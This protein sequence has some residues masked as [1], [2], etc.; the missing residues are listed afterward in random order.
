MIHAGDERVPPPSPPRLPGTVVYRPC[1]DDLIDAVLADLLLQSQSCVRAFGDFHLA[2]CA[3]ERIEPALVRLMLDPMYRSLPWKRTHLW[4]ADDCV[5]GADDDRSRAKRM[6]EIL[7][8]H[9]DIPVDQVHGI[10]VTSR[11]PGGQYQADLQESLAWRE[12]GQ[13]RLDFAL[14]TLA[15]GGPVSA[16]LAG[17]SGLADDGDLV[18]R[19]AWRCR[20]GL[21]WYGLSTRMISATRLIAIVATGTTARDAVRAIAPSHG[22]RPPRDIRPIGG[23]LRWYLDQTA[24]PDEPGSPSV[25]SP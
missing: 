14:L 3:S 4:M 1:F 12:K 19:R 10:P 16:A 22:G 2:V 11:D 8:E 15:D 17:A 21:E 9:S 20:E 7:V 18:I 24:C 5:V 23:E 25:E 13:D 6:R